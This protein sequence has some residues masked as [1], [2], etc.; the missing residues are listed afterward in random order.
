MKIATWNL[1]QVISGSPKALQ[2]QQWIARV[3]ADIWVFTETN[4]DM[5]PGPEYYGVASQPAATA[6]DPKQRHVQIWV[7]NQPLIPIITRDPVTSACGLMQLQTGSTWLIYGMVLPLP[8]NPYPDV[9]HEQAFM[10]ALRD[11]QADWQ[12]LQAT[13]PEAMLIVAGDFNQDLNVL[14]Y[15]GSRRNKQ[16]LRQALAEANLDCLTFGDNDPVRRL[17]DGQHSNIDHICIAHPD[18]ISLQGS[19]AWPDSLENLRGI[20]DHFGVGLE[21]F[22]AP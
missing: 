14:P 19:F 15:Y 3:N 8:D 20:A 9:S 5:G 22:L 17:I 11:R 1:E 12:S 4:L 16:A 21:F 2:Q 6:G 10:A 7:R 18:A 13:Y